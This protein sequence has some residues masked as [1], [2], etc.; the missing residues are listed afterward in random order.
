MEREHRCEPEGRTVSFMK[1]FFTHWFHAWRSLLQEKKYRVSFLIGLLLLG[2]AYYI[3]FRAVLYT[4]QIA[5]VSVPDLI[6]DNIPTVDLSFI[7]TFGIYLTALIVVFYPL[8]V[9]PEIVPF[10]A[11]TVAIF[12]IIRAFFISLTHIGAPEGYFRLP[13]FED[14]PGA[15]RLFYTNDLFFS[16]HTGFSFLAALLFWENRWLRYFF[17][18]MSVAQSITVLF[19]HV[20]YS[21]DVFSAYFITYSIYVVSDKVFNELNLS[22]QRIVERMKKFQMPISKE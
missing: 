22:F 16:G 17:I 10:T 14:Q 19:M 8:F 18:G 5:V 3:N 1:N 13:G 4:D 21:I 7:F 15:F 12:I 11:K 9:K 20:H 6:L 2:L